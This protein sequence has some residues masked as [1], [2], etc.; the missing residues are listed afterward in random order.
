V[1]GR[2]L[3]ARA[4]AV[5]RAVLVACLLGGSWAAAGHPAS[6]AVNTAPDAAT[7]AMSQGLAALRAEVRQ[8][9]LLA[10][11]AKGGYTGRL[12]A[13][14]GQLP[15]ALQLQRQIRAQKDLLLLLEEQRTVARAGV[16]RLRRGVRDDLSTLGTALG[17]QSAVV[18]TTAQS[19]AITATVA[20]SQARLDV[21]VHADSLV[22]NMQAS[23]RVLAVLALNVRT[24][25][26]A[27][28][29]AA[30]LRALAQGVHLNVGAMMRAL[31]L[32]ARADPAA[33]ADAQS[34]LAT[35]LTGAI[36]SLN[37][38]LT[39]TLDARQ[40]RLRLSIARLQAQL[41]G[42]LSRAAVTL[43]ALQ[44][45]VLAGEVVAAPLSAAYRQ[46]VAAGLSPVAR[47]LGDAAAAST[48]LA[49]RLAD[50]GALQDAQARIDREVGQAQADLEAGLSQA[51]A[52]L[53]GRLRSDVTMTISDTEQT[54]HVH[55]DRI[56]VAALARD[57]DFNVTMG[58]SVLR[59]AALHAEVTPSTRNLRGSPR[60]EI[61]G[62]DLLLHAQLHGL[63]ARVRT[64]VAAVRAAQD[65]LSRIV[66]G[67]VATLRGT[68]ANI[69]VPLVNRYSSEI[70]H[71]QATLDG[72]LAAASA[73]MGR[74][75]AHLS[76]RAYLA[77]ARGRVIV[78]AVAL[79]SE[80][81]TTSAP[82]AGWIHRG[83]SVA[84]IGYVWGAAVRHPLGGA[85]D[86]R[87]YVLPRAA[88]Q[89]GYLYVPAALV[90]TSSA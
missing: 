16:D 30:Q 56:S 27:Q 87:W 73:G 69:L 48:T 54:V 37:E 18:S 84:L 23:A 63:Q 66:R 41:T 67:R 55:L 57:L 53:Q 26:D 85:L 33:A 60:A 29:M 22:L 43:G 45:D 34:G 71:L 58:L 28:R 61:S 64:D 52:A 76:A 74:T 70:A 81:S 39:G 78:A 9:P 14:A 4:R 24:H 82:V 79:R 1:A 51:D 83:A 12:D 47:A 46:G 20:I 19:L 90:V 77:P 42:V 31:T 68:L 36:K 75:R 40:S 65:T 6:A 17:E 38:S 49:S 88:G 35:G 8:S 3:G 50:L 21:R 5:P 25:L 7:M 44:H 62:V 89:A 72:A 32:L 59:I 10:P 13:L 15:L 11:A 86:R 80:P 2:F